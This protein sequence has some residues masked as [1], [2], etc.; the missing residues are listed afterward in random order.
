MNEMCLRYAMGPKADMGIYTCINSNKFHVNACN[1]DS[2]THAL[3]LTS[4]RTTVLLYRYTQLSFV[5]W[6][7]DTNKI[8]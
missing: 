8:K 1:L 7:S 3:T 5:S 2:L 6:K 4:I